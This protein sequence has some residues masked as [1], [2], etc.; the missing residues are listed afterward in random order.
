MSSGG[1]GSAVFTLFA[2]NGP[3]VQALRRAEVQASAFV[4]K[5]RGLEYAGVNVFSALGKTVGVFTSAMKNAALATAALIG[6]GAVGLTKLGVM[7]VKLA[8]N[9]AEVENKFNVLFGSFAKRSKGELF[10][11]GNEVGRS[12]GELL[13]MAA[14]FKGITRQFNISESAASSMAV[15]LAKL[16]VDLGS[17]N[18]VADK[19]AA[20][21]LYSGLIGNHE[22]IRRLNVFLSEASIR[23]ELLRMGF[24]GTF[25][26]ASDQAKQLARLNIILRDTSVAQGD[27]SRT[28]G[29]H[30]NQMRAFSAV[31]KTT[32][33]Q[34][35]QAL[36]PSLQVIIQM[37]IDFARVVSA[38][39]GPIVAYGQIVSWVFQ[40]VANI[41]RETA[42]MLYNYDLTWAMLK[43]TIANAVVDMYEKV[44]WFAQSAMGGFKWLWDNL[45][46]LS[47]STAANIITVFRNMQANI[48]KIVIE[49]WAFVASKGRDA[50]DFT[51]RDL[52][53]GTSSLNLD[54]LMEALNPAPNST[55]LQRLQ[56]YNELL[57]EYGRRK[58]EMDEMLGRNK[59]DHSQRGFD[60]GQF[61]DNAEKKIK[62]EI[63]ANEQLFRKN[64]ID[65]FDTKDDKLLQVNEQQLVQQ[66]K[67]ANDAKAQHVELINA[68][69][70]NGITIK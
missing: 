1:L 54:G 33:V 50:I 26:D 53:A 34:I 7:S 22:A 15:Q 45:L 63:V 38:N 8:S 25:E 67:D 4:M 3:F 57:Q 10:S 40:A 49:S 43:F 47:L 68:V 36:I 58:N 65:A 48:A 51:T 23:T 24:K 2:N 27:A 46:Q 14:N 60:I 18:N 42:F 13:D 41:I 9:F 62:V 55:A 28:S 31:L 66:Q 20:Q 17:F 44:A 16:A 37:M 39:I 5:M 70:G 64:L 59:S 32:G 69:K 29:S 19:E 35:G 56:M 61:G 21:R 6:I 12:K 52:A 30:A 11:F